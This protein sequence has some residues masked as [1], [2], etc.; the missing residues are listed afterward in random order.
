MGAGIAGCVLAGR[1]A[2]ADR[3]VLLID[4][5]PGGPPSAAG[6]ASFFESLAEPGRTRSGF[7]VQPTRL[8][9][10]RPYQ[11][12]QGIGGGSVVNAM[13]ATPGRPADYDRWEGEFGC[14][15][16][17]WASLRWT[18]DA[19]LLPTT[20][21]HREEFG[22]VDRALIDAAVGLGHHGSGSKLVDGG[23]GVGPAWLTR[24]DGR[25]VTA[26]DAYLPLGGDHLTVRANARAERVI[27]DGTDA[28]GVLLA[29]GE[30]IEAGEVI[31]CAGA[32][33]SPAILLRSGVIRQGI[34]VGLKDH[35]SAS[36]GMQ[37]LEPNDSKGL[38]AATL[39]RWSSTGY[40][41]DDGGDGDL[42]LLPL[43]HLGSRASSAGSAGLVAAVMFVHSTGTVAIDDRDP[44]APPIVR[45]NMLDDERDRRR[46]R[47]AVRHMAA[48]VATDPFRRITRDVSIDEQGTP[49]AAL[50]EDEDGLDRWMMNGVGDFFHAACTCRM[51]P[52]T[53]DL[54]VVD[55]AGSVHG[56]DR[57]R[58][59]DA[60]IFPDLPRA[61]P[62][63]PTVMVAEQI[64]AMMLAS[65]S[66]G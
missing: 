66:N 22:S 14:A 53:D 37:L 23:L 21:P 32:I 56:Y 26:A 3:D 13:L 28:I 44:T 41:G 17:G 4:A 52:V 50:A 49:L 31:V 24:R 54:A 29:T 27:M 15:G 38:A 20:Q 35:P 5:G 2:A 61:N 8:D 7:T 25:R 57:L 51:G 60:S 46:L 64:A 43:N 34:G 40:G 39:L 19:Q 12:G 62:A 10:T 65:D 33:E 63:L 36:F 6:E 59:C 48:L 9:V 16:W 45:I 11:L 1:L 55:P 42:Q 58:V 18:L 47:E 30:F